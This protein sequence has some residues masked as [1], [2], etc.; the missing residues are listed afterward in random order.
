MEQLTI[1]Q[2]YPSRLRQTIRLRVARFWD[3][4]VPGTRI[5]QGIAFIGTDCTIGAPT[6]NNITAPTAPQA[7]ILQPTAI[8]ITNYPRHF[9]D[10]TIEESSDL[11]GQ[12]RQIP[13]S[14]LDIEALTTMDPKLVMIFAGMIVRTFN[15][16][17]YLMS[18]STS[19]IYVNL[20]IPEVGS[21]KLIYLEKETPRE[22]FDK[23][24]ILRNSSKCKFN[25]SSGLP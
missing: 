23:K 17:T 7:T 25:S 9:F 11:L 14:R 6:A 3:C 16:G 4:I 1:A 10:F 2:L 13:C 20:E 22:T 8:D 5:F 15:R 21:V 12:P 19:K 18:C 24:S